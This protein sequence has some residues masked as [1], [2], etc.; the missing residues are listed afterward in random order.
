M[1]IFDITRSKNI[2]SGRQFFF[3]E[4]VLTRTTVMESST[5]KASRMKNLEQP[6]RTITSFH[7]CSSLFV[8]G[9]G[10]RW[11]HGQDGNFLHTMKLEQELTVYWSQDPYIRM[12]LHDGD[13]DAGGPH[14][15]ETLKTTTK[16]NAGGN[17]NWNEK[18]VI[19]KPGVPS[20]IRNKDGFDSSNLNVLNFYTRFREHGRPQIRAVRLRHSER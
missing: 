13:F 20:S 3:L 8:W 6:S 18:F 4:K 19:N 17:A 1:K 2:I 16:D 12:T 9:A 5:W 14:R 11:L 15:G 10:F 7:L